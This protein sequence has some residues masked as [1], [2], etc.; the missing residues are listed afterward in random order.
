MDGRFDDYEDCPLESSDY[1]LIEKARVVAEPDW[2]NANKSDFNTVISKTQQSLDAYSDDDNPDVLDPDDVP[3]ILW[4][5]R[6]PYGTLNHEDSPKKVIRNHK[7][8]WRVENSYGDKK[9]KLIA[10]SG[11]RHHGVCVFLFWL[12]TL[13]YN[14]WIL[15]RVFLRQDYPNHRPQDRGAVQLT[16]FLMRSCV[17]TTGS[18]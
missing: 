5:A 9:T 1:N 11:S 18:A 12:S 3:N 6:R 8:R 15:T 2:N 7:Q 16:T 17:W 13:L 4:K 14:G 10:R